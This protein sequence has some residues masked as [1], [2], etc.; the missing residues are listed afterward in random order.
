[1]SMTEKDLLKKLLTKRELEIIEAICA[2]DDCDSQIEGL[3]E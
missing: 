3:L 1:M 2:T